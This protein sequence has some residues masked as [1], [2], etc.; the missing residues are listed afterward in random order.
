MQH[1]TQDDA[2]PLTWKK[3]LLA[4][5]QFLV[6]FYVATFCLGMLFLHRGANWQ[7]PGVVIGILY[8]LLVVF[9]AVRM[10]RKF[11]MA[12][13]MVASPT[14][15]LCMLVIVVSLLPT[16][17]AVDQRLHFTQSG[18]NHL[19]VQKQAAILPQAGRESGK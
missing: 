15:P 16:L 11:S 13:V 14:I 12:A 5:L 2:Q 1:P 9:S 17:Q 10:V 6:I 19:S 7:L 8:V 3:Y 4:G 18:N